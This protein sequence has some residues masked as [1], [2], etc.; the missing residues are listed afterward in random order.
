MS[1][2]DLI[3]KIATTTINE[4]RPRPQ[5]ATVT[6]IDRLTNKCWVKFTGETISV[7]VAMGSIQPYSVGQLVRIE[8]LTGDR[9]VSDVIGKATDTFDTQMSA[10]HA[11]LS[12]S[13]IEPVKIA[14][15]GSS[16]TFG[17]NAT[18][19]S[20]R[21]VNKVIERLQ[22]SYPNGIEFYDSPTVALGT[23]GDNFNG[24]QGFNGGIGG[25]FANSYAPSGTITALDALNPQVVF[26]MIGANDYFLGVTPA[27]YKTNVLAAIAAIDA[28]TTTRHVLLH[29]YRRPDVASPAYPWWQ[30]G[31]ALR[32]I[33]A[34]AAN[35][36][37]VDI[38]EDYEEV[39]ALGVDPYD[40]ISPDAIH[41]T[42]SGHDFMANAIL[43]QLGIPEPRDP[44]PAQVVDLFNRAA[45]AVGNTN[46]GQ[47]WIT[48]T[49]TLTVAAGKGVF[50]SAGN[51][52]VDT[53]ILDQDVS[54]IVAPTATN[55][56]MGVTFRVVDATTR[57]LASLDPLTGN[58]ELWAT[59]SGGTVSIATAA[60]GAVANKL[61]HIR[62]HVI[63]DTVNVYLN[64]K[65]YIT[66]TMNST[67]MLTWGT[68]TRAGLRSPVAG[69]AF[70]NFAVRPAR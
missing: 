50:S 40:L 6:Q 46:T 65:R 47:A 9:Y 53:T 62:A 37:Y 19:P 21:W 61:W 42:D 51:A 28:V 38:S 45:G 54:A 44:K 66:W 4:L 60:A 49:G 16:T 34:G 52:S 15:L 43:R 41:Q 22:R 23:T 56:R 48:E 70:S 5:I 7:P 17:L 27:S 26:H 11:V 36:A 30:Y 39:A 13:Q 33:A 2:R 1:I 55:H 18:I 64:G 67:Q 58:V 59:N 12:T 63:G 32:E 24:I 10:L 20:R 69:P 3:V 57:L 29:T 14:F 25:A 68:G 35:V 31:N 8:G